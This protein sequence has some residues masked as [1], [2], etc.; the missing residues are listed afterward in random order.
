MGKSKIVE[1][2]TGGLEEV[3]P[4]KTWT[5]P[6]VRELEIEKDTE[7]GVSG[8]NDGGTLS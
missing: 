2:E 1:P 3:T 4:K 5:P 6:V 8:V 7:F